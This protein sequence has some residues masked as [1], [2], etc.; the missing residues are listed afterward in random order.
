MHTI[1]ALEEAIAAAEAL[2]YGI[3]REWMGG[4]GGGV[5]EIA[6]RKW[7]FIDL[8]MTAAEQLDQIVISLG[9]DP[10]IYGQ[11]LSPQLSRLLG[12]RKSA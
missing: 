3:R 9:E 5:C 4:C 2:G 11:T 7:I 10:A 12:I 1:E 8:S 6:G